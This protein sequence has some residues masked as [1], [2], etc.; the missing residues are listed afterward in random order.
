MAEI[1]HAYA[2]VS[3]RDF[4]RKYGLDNRRSN[5]EVVTHAENIRRGKRRKRLQAEGMVTE[6]DHRSPQL[7]FDS[8]TT[9]G[10][11][12]SVNLSVNPTNQI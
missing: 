10:V 6:I 1:I 12:N 8:M 3:E 2:C 4:Q 9:L 5:L 7:T 11:G